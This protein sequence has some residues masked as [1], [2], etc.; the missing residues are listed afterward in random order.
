MLPADTIE[1]QTTIL[2]AVLLD[3]VQNNEK[4]TNISNLIEIPL[5]S[6]KSISNPSTEIIN[7]QQSRPASANISVPVFLLSNVMSLV[8]KIDEVRVVTNSMSPDFISIKETWLQGHVDS[9][10]VELNGYVLVRKDRHSGIHGGICMYLKNNIPTR[11]PRGVYS[12]IG[13][14]YHPTNADNSKI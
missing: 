13:T 5:S 6:S 3:V 10:V 7:N 14:V 1:R 9:N 4:H 2:P 12:V 8:P 11:L